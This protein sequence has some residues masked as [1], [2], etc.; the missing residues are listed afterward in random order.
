MPGLIAGNV[1]PADEVPPTASE[2]SPLE[3]AFR[4]AL[5]PAWGQLTNG[6]RKKAVVLFSVQTYIYTR[7]V[8][9]TRRAWEAQREADRLTALGSEDPGVLADLSAAEA[10]SQNH[11]DRRRD[12]LFWALV[13]GFYG[14]MDAY[15][16]AQL[17]D[18]EGELDKDRSLFGGIDPAQGT[19]ELGLRF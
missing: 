9:E 1:L 4:S 3:R 18:F 19:V 13:G 8:L 5:F 2:P 7:L 12:L 15:I 14:A 11:F 16:D 6:R 10:A 17:G